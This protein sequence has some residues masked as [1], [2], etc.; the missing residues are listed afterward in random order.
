L[1]PAA[2]VPTFS[3]SA[4]FQPADT[5]REAGWKPALPC[6]VGLQR[7]QPCRIETKERGERARLAVLP[8]LPKTGD[9]LGLVL[10]NVEDGVELGDLKQVVNLFGEIQKLQLPP[11]V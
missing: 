11:L 6:F 10:V 5:G 4:G 9:G 8:L 2:G 7:Q 1:S 3:G